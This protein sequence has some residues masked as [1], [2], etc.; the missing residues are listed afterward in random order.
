V[1][2]C[3]RD[4]VETDNLQRQTLFTE[5]D[6]A[7]GLPKAEAARRRL[8]GINSTVT[9][10]GIVTDV[11]PSNI[12]E[13]VSG[14][15]L[16]LDG[17]DNFETRY[18]INDVAVKHAVPWIYGAAVAA[19]GLA[20]PILPG[21]TPCLRCV[22]ED[23]PPPELSPTC[24]TIGVIGPL[25]H[26]VAGAEAADA[27]KILTGNRDAVTR[28]LTSIDAWSGRYTPIHVQ[29]ARERG[30]C[31]CCRQ[32]RFEYLEGDRFGSAGHLCGRGA[33]Q[34]HRT[35][36]P[37]VD[38]RALADKLERV[39]GGTIRV[40]EYLLQ[41]TVGEYEITVFVDGRALIKGTD[42]PDVAK[43]VYARYVGA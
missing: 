36:G 32:R 3:D 42:D 13:L 21:E 2:I 29:S 15:D 27:L 5:Q 43:T 40:N 9:V 18:L 8:S 17:T 12:E 41:A 1:R 38:L 31:V 24:D 22:F 7:D 16:M 28:H 11:N 33:I 26:L 35:G 34:I 37:T 20:M 30:D 19:V 4:Y 23:A 25:I 10:E 6:V 39:A 14:A